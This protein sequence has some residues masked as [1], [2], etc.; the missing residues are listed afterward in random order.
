[1]WNAELAAEFSEAKERWFK[2]KFAGRGATLKHKTRERFLAPGF[3]KWGQTNV[4]PELLSAFEQQLNLSFHQTPCKKMHVFVER[5][6]TCALCEM[7]NAYATATEATRICGV[8]RKT[9]EGKTYAMRR[10]AE[11]G[12]ESLKTSKAEIDAKRIATCMERYGATTPW[13]SK[14]AKKT[15]MK[16]KRATCLEKYGHEHPLLNPA[17]ARRQQMSAFALKSIRLRGKTFEYQGYEDYALRIL[18]KNRGAKNVLSQYDSAFPALELPHYFRPDIY[19]VTADAYVEVKS[20]YTLVHK[21]YLKL[22]RRKA[23]ES[24]EAG[25]SVTWLIVS[26]CRTKHRKLPDDWY[27]WHKPVLVKFLDGII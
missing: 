14:S 26:S 1:M 5:L 23:R 2:S 7:C 11:L 16:K 25:Y 19:V 24:F 21:N 13:Q 15:I 20:T 27:T 3:L 22:N 18:V 17:I 10:A 6:E 8:C 4:R 9:P 12:A